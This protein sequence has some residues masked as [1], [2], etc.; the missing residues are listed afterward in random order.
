MV[1]AKTGPEGPSVID[2]L[3]EVSE[4]I[5]SNRGDVDKVMEAAGRLD[6]L[7]SYMVDTSTYV[8]LEKENAKG[9][10]DP[11]RKVTKKNESM[12]GHDIKRRSTFR[13]SDWDQSDQ[14]DSTSGTEG[15]D[16]NQNSD[17]GDFE[18]SSSWR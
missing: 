1:Y 17:R 5:G 3:K 8:T 6:H 4:Y 18:K 10:K 14:P 2:S 11:I 16:G 7:I 9:K 15:D 12:G 13:K